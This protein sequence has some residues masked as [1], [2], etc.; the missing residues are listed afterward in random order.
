MFAAYSCEDCSRNPD[1]CSKRW[2]TRRGYSVS[3][4][5]ENVA[6]PA[7]WLTRSSNDNFPSASSLRNAKATKVFE[8]DP[9][10]NIVSGVTT[11]P[12]ARSATPNSAAHRIL[13]LETRTTPPPG[14]LVSCKTSS[15]AL[16]SSTIVFGGELGFSS[17][18]D[19]RVAIA[20]E[21]PRQNATRAT[22]RV[23]IYRLAWPLGAINYSK[24]RRMPK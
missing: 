1:V 24:S 20:Q 21:T 2:T 10:R 22:Q 16:C 23:S 7:R 15:I 9:A 14:V 11:W 8:I 3:H 4:G 17:A 19:G 5:L 13:S 12:D 6:S 18:T